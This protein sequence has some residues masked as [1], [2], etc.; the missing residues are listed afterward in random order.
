MANG[1]CPY[2]LAHLKAVAGCNTPSSK[3]TPPGFLRSLLVNKP[4]TEIVN[5]DSLK[6]D[7]GNGHIREV[8]LKYRKRAVPQAVATSDNCDIDIA[9]QYNEV[10]LPLT[11]FAKYGIYISDE[12][13]SRYCADATA[14]RRPNGWPTPFM[15]DFLNA[16]MES[17]NGVLGKMDQTL[18]TKMLT[19]FGINVVTGT[20]AASTVNINPDANIRDLEDGVTKILADAIEN[21]M[22]GELVFWGSGLFN[23]YTIQQIAACCAANGLDTS[24]F[25]GYQWFNDLYAKAILGT[26]QIGVYSKGSLGLIEIDRFRGFRA[27]DKG[28]S[29]FF[30][31]PLP[32]DCP[33]CN[34]GLLDMN[35]DFQ[36]KYFDCPT[37][38]NVGCEGEQTIDRGYVLF[39][40]KAYDL[41]SIPTDA[42]QHTAYGDCYNDRLAGNN[43]TLRYIITNA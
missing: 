30:N 34:G 15:D 25:T 16:V 41:F 5:R 40:S 10:T 24:M 3:V 33:E 19:K 26:N 28:T 12:D 35:F 4:T 22:C 21:E 18:N 13:L 8:R 7:E 11:E 6:L 23:N 42:Y 36:L 20:N 43:G 1:F 2:F 17:A 29:Q 27:G 39:I 32:I 38:I 9:P 14:M 37:T 31:A